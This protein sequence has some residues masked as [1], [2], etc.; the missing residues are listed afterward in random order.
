M[1]TGDNFDNLVAMVQNSSCA[2]KTGSVTDNNVVFHSRSAG[3]LQ[4]V[5]PD[6]E[7]FSIS[8]AC[9]TILSHLSY[10]DIVGP[11]FT[12]WRARFRC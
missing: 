10:Q 5:A 7:L 3:I 9:F 8:L 1:I 6:H 4:H 2:R 11:A 12:N